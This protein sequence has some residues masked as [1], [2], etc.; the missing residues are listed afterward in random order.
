MTRKGAT[1]LV[2]SLA[3]WML[4]VSGFV[5][6]IGWKNPVH[7]AVLG[8]AWGLIVLWVGGCG[9]TMWR[10]RELWR[11]LTVRVRLP[12]SLKFV[13]GCT[14]LALVEEAVTTLMTNCA[15]LFGVSVGQ[16]YITASASY[17]D[18]V[19]YHS[20]VVFLPMFIGWWVMLRR[21]RFSPLAVFVLFG[22]TGLVAET[23]TFGLQ[24][25]GSFAF[26]IF[27]YGLMVWLPAYCVPEDRPARQ[28]RWW[29]YPLAVVIP[30]LFLPLMGV[31][32]PWLWLT[33]K[34]P[35]IHFPPSH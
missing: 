13:M 18:V 27:V 20:V 31:L 21:W 14:M 26:W 35:P 33:P 17:L 2:L 30:F 4:L 6:A 23:L 34:H 9:L 3:A 8:M 15:P 24:N 32:A 12:W 22:L 11:R 25:L 28:P 7:R 29:A 10:W 1:I 16:A 19:L 5:L